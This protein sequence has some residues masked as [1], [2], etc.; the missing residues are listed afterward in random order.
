MCGIFSLF[1]ILSHL[2]DIQH[3][4]LLKNH[5][6]SE[7]GVGSDSGSCSGSISNPEC[8]YDYTLKEIIRKFEIEIDDFFMR[9]IGRGPEFSVLKSYIAEMNSLLG[10]HRLAINGLD[11]GS[12]QPIYHNGKILICN[13]EIYNYKEIYAML[14][15]EP[16]TNS[17]CEAILH[18]YEKFG[19]EKTLRHLDGVFAFV[20]IDC[21]IM[22][23]D[24]GDGVGGG[25]GAGVGGNSGFNNPVSYMNALQ[26]NI[27]MFVARDPYG[28][29]PLYKFSLPDYGN[30]ENIFG[31]TS[32]M[33][34]IL[35]EGIYNTIGASVFKIYDVLFPRQDIHIEQFQPGTYST[36]FLGNSASQHT[37]HLYWKPIQENTPYC[38]VEML[39]GNVSIE[40]EDIACSLIR[41]S[42]ENAV[43]KRVTTTDRPVACLLSGGLDSSLIT[44][45]VH[46]YYKHKN[47]GN[48]KDVVLETYSIGMEGSEDLKYARKVADYL[49]TKHT[50]VVLTE[51][52]FLNAIPEVIYAIE[53]YD[54]TTVRASVGNY[55][56]SKYISQHSEAKVIFNGDGSD[57]VCG[58]YMYFHC[59]PSSYEFD[60]ECKRL[61]KDICY[62]DVL[63]SDRSISSNGLEPRTPFLDKS[64]VQAYLSI[65]K[66]LR[67]TTH[68]H[69]CEKY[70]LRKAFSGMKLLPQEV[71]WRTK[72]A[73]SDG[74]SKQTRSWYQIIQEHVETMPAGG[75]GACI[76][77]DPYDCENRFVYRFNTPQTK[78]QTYYRNLF[79][80]F[81]GAFCGNVIPYFWMPRFVEGAVDASARTLAI[82]NK[83]KTEN[84]CES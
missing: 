65:S 7:S 84:D 62:F 60:D 83:K 20:L 73:F 45:L 15:I 32:E 59:A 48:G 40:K 11:D 56:I 54:T 6:R 72:E 27:K 26:K 42:L 49:G 25:A 41:E 37:E 68:M 1:N 79:H 4:N 30:Y 39:H 5:S 47:K 71:L 12:N 2:K 44:A 61:L 50:E 63:R 19:I 34:M 77:E 52:D 28:V 36:F 55:L 33:K 21:N 22:S 24:V 69:K 58:G 35:N 14:D 8:Q 76:D 80:H 82:Y 3:R 46:K 53:S 74:V 78:E 16:S 31:F 38:N 51:N 18:L 66:E 70:L 81:F 57:E 67:Y 64:F 9:G 29:R 43:L 13:G 23:D 17:D 75:V 10:F